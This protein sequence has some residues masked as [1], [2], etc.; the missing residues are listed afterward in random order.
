MMRLLLSVAVASKGRRASDGAEARVRWRSSSTQLGGLGVQMRA[1]SFASRSPLAQTQAEINST[2][3]MEWDRRLLF[4]LGVAN[5]R[6]YELRLQAPEAKFEDSEV[7][8][9]V[10]PARIPRPAL[11]PPPG[12]AC[13]ALILLHAASSSTSPQFMYA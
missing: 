5:R 9:P 8:A 6:L 1:Q 13:L 10:F 12:P 7:H 3:V 4:T 2:F 11:R